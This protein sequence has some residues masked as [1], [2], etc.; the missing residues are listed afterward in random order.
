MPS[1][2]LNQIVQSLLP[3]ARVEPFAL[4]ELSIELQL[5]N[6]DFPREQIPQEVAM[7]LMEEP[8][9]W[10]FCWA[11]GAVLA[12]YLL[13]HPALV[14]GK[15]VMDF[16]SG[17]GVVAIAAAKAG[18]AEVV[19]CDIDP[20]AL[21]ATETNA[22]LNQVQLTLS[23]DFDRVEGELDLIVAAD[24]L[25]DRANLP[26]L[27]RFQERAA[28]VLIGDSRI[29]QFD[30]PGYRKLDEVDACTLPDLDESAEFRRVSI[31]GA[32]AWPRPGTV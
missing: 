14:A 10:A 3:G 11:S 31:Y 16:G 2:D 23:G 21:I 7:R 8:F 24:V 19:A 30:F 6:A 12:R 29:R 18:A 22:E 13:D 20:A 26:W 5:I 32:G 15:R 1:S 25:Y 9:Y 27:R 4:P 17:S 28:S